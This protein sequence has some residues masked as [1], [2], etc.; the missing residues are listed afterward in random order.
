[1]I[2]TVQLAPEAQLTPSTVNVPV[3][4][5]DAITI[6]VYFHSSDERVYVRIDGEKVEGE[7]DDVTS[8]VVVGDGV[9]PVTV[10]AL[11]VGVALV[12][13]YTNAPST[14]ENTVMTLTPTP[15]GTLPHAIVDWQVMPLIVSTPL[16]NVDVIETPIVI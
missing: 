8:R 7:R 13:V 14:V 15:T 6:D 5:V 3:A 10:I 2:G 12:T 1:M 16:A 4:N 11:I 9:E